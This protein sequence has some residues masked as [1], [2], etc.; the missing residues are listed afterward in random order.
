MTAPPLTELDQAA[1]RFAVD[2][3]DHTLTVLHSDGLYRHL[4]FRGKNFMY[5]FDIITWPGNLVLNGDMGSW[6]FSRLEDMFEFFT[7]PVN[8]SY[9]AEKLRA[10]D[11]NGLERFSNNKFRAVVQQQVEE[12]LEDEPDPEYRAGLTKAVQEEILSQWVDDVHQAVEILDNFSY[13]GR[14]FTD[15]WEL[16]D[17]MTEYSPQ[18]LW[19]LCAIP[20]GIGQYR[21]R[22]Q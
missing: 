22:D 15:V 19:S 9:W 10:Q 17:L 3:K 20:W 21:N 1:Q 7:G 5:W 12:F 13:S 11:R 16:G 8:D 6:H 4:S 2:T 14:S 18:F